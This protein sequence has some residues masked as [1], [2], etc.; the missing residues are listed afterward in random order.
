LVPRDALHLGASPRAATRRRARRVRGTQQPAAGQREPGNE[1]DDELS[2]KPYPHEGVL[3]FLF[4]RPVFC[5]DAV[6][7]DIAKYNGYEKIF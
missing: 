7:I 3:A 6:N 2:E 1:H 4:H 5:V